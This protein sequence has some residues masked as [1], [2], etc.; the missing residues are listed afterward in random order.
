MEAE[1][2]LRSGVEAAARRLPRWQRGR[3]WPAA[4]AQRCPGAPPRRSSPPT[5]SEG[6]AAVREPGAARSAGSG[7]LAE[8][9]VALARRPPPLLRTAPRRRAADHG[10]DQGPPGG[11]GPQPVARYVPPYYPPPPLRLR[12]P[13]PD[14]PRPGIQLPGAGRG[15]LPG[16]DL[17]GSRGRGS[18]GNWLQSSDS[19]KFRARGRRAE[20]ARG[21]DFGGVEETR[22]EKRRGLVAPPGA[23][24]T[25][26]RP[27]ELSAPPRGS[28]AVPG[29]PRARVL[30]EGRGQ[31]AWRKHP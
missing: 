25:T 14:P 29:A 16:S 1:G 18:P 31:G 26:K 23:L 4:R 2:E 8:E 12:E 11:V 24:L 13:L 22:V 6:A 3:D 21:R 10:P 17:G 9:A 28:L 5:S 20:A 27:A 15:A 19:A 30:S 7:R